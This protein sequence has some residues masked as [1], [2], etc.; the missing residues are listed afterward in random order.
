VICSLF[1]TL[2]VTL[3]PQLSPDLTQQQVDPLALPG[4]ALPQGQ[5]GRRKGD[6][7][8]FVDGAGQ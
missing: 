7:F 5:N 4:F 2:L 3:N 8:I 1:L 6:R